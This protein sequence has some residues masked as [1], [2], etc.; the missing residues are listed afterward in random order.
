MKKVNSKNKHMSS[1][2]LTRD[3]G[4]ITSGNEDEI[5]NILDD[6]SVDSEDDDFEED[7]FANSKHGKATQSPDQESESEKRHLGRQ[8][9]GD[10]V[11]RA[12]S[13]P[14]VVSD[15]EINLVLSKLGKSFSLTRKKMEFFVNE[16]L[17][18]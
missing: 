14:D 6:L 7:D 2:Q 13:V 3:L 16:S 9:D 15:N 4:A 11:N 10:G 8:L 17:T 12:E 1:S 18:R 5:C